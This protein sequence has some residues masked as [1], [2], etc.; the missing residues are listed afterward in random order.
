MKYTINKKN[1]A[2]SEIFEAW[3]AASGCGS[4]SAMK[5][6]IWFVRFQNFSKTVP[7]GPPMAHAA[8]PSGI[9]VQPMSGAK[10]TFEKLAAGWATLS[11]IKSGNNN[12]QISV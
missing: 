5:A 3:L 1:A 12:H 7:S 11:G 2:M 9:N 8:K 4:R 10:S 6:S